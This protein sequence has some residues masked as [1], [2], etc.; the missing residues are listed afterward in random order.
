MAMIS[1]NVYK[2]EMEDEIYFT[3]VQPNQ[4]E[5]FYTAEIEDLEDFEKVSLASPGSIMEQ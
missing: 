4:A 2:K 5:D 1:C 3:F